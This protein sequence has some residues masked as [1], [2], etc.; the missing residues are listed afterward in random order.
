MKEGDSL[1][2]FLKNS[3][4]RKSL[5][6]DFLV[7]KDSHIH[8]GIC[9]STSVVDDDHSNEGITLIVPTSGVV[10]TLVV[11]RSPKR[12]EPLDPRHVL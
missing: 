8:G 3:P 2:V 10:L 1:N 11:D 4:R 12:Q 6:W 5:G 7:N 9:Q